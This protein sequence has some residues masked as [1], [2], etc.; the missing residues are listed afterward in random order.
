MGSTTRRM[1]HTFKPD[2]IRQ[3]AVF[4]KPEI[5]YECL[6]KMYNELEDQYERAIKRFENSS[7][8]PN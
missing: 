2:E 4:Q 6:T 1:N 8:R 7:V 3:A 5:R